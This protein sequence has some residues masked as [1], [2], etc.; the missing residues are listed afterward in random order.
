MPRYGEGMR[1]HRAI[2]CRTRG[3]ALLLGTSHGLSYLRADGGFGQLRSDFEEPDLALNAPKHPN[4]QTTVHGKK[5]SDGLGAAPLCGE[6][7]H[8]RSGNRRNKDL[9]LGLG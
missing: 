5:E 4:I 7:E 2:G 3:T 1:C 9:C 8:G 6:T